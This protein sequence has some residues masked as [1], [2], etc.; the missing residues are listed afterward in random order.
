M[1]TLTP[2]C[3]ASAHKHTHR[4][5]HHDRDKYYRL[6]KEKGYRSRAAFKLLQLN[7]PYKFLQSSHSL[8]DLCAAPGGWTQVAREALPRDS[9]IVA[10][11][12]LPIKPIP[13][14]VTHIADITT[15]KAHSLI[16]QTMSGSKVSTVL[17]DGAPNL[18][19]TAY[20]RDAFLQ[21]EIVLLSLKC[22][23]EH[24]QK[25]GTFVTKVYRSPQYTSLTWVLKQLFN[26]V[27][28][29]K[30]QS[31]RSASSEIFLVCSD[32][33]APSK[34]D[35]RFFQPKDVFE[36]NITVGHK[37]L[38]VFDKDYGKK[39]RS[40]QGYGEDLGLTLRKT[41]TA[42]DFIKGDAPIDVLSDVNAI[43]EDLPDLEVWGKATDEVKGWFAD[44]RVLG[45]S[46]FKTLLKWR[47]QVRVELGLDEA[48]EA[49][50]KKVKKVRDRSERERDVEED[51]E[52]AIREKRG[53]EKRERKKE[54]ERKER[55]RRR[56]VAG[57]EGEGLVEEEDGVFDLGKGK[58]GMHEV[59]LDDY[60]ASVLEDKEEEE[61]E[62]DLDLEH[63]MDEEVRRV[64]AP[65]RR[66]T[67]RDPRCCRGQPT[68]CR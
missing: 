52:R 13:G 46:E 38:S 64:R 40:R 25:G 31:S 11:D 30:P 5:K 4:T 55:V 33:K 59:R 22:A 65:A 3:I 12:I 20:D 63:D 45:K 18:T 37:K 68:P 53:R 39:Q 14:V 35:P 29:V 57:L 36:D 58:K 49:G 60:D 26:T 28:A 17:C 15:D 66:R 34:V 21:N 56:K 27:D 48:K 41:V 1:N 42:L 47:E 8:I 67:Q 10:L 16:R 7:K 23:C 50:N 51:I 44:L 2:P 9:T 62:D 54:R 24:L 43:V 32:F 61:E 19:G 6:A